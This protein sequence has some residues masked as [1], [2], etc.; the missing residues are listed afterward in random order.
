VTVYVE[1]GEMTISEAYDAY[2]KGE[3]NAF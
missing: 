2:K 1:A 3:L